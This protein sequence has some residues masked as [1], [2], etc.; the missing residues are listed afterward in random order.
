M[1]AGEG[2]EASDLLEA[3]AAEAPRQG[4]AVV[5]RWARDLRARVPLRSGRPAPNPLATLTPRELEV[6]ALVAEG[7]TNPQIGRRLNMAAKT[8]SV[9]VSAI[10]AKLGAATRTQAAGLYVAA[11]PAPL[12]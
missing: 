8:A 7:L 6:L 3:I 4:V 11:R 12:A 9:H 1:H 5:G 2:A 10:L